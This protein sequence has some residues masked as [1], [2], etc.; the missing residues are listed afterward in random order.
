MA[1]FDL[2]ELCRNLAEK[3]I[4]YREDDKI[5][6]PNAEHVKR[7]ISQFDDIKR[8]SILQEMIHIM[9]KVYFSKSK[10]MDFLQ[11]KV[12]NSKLVGND[13]VAFWNDVTLLDIQQGSRSQSKMKSL[14]S[15]IL[16][17]KYGININKVNSN[18]GIYIYLDDVCFSG[19]RIKNDIIKWLS[20]VNIKGLTINKINIIT[21]ANHSNGTWWAE[22]GIN[23]EMRKLN[24]NFKIDFWTCHTYKNMLSQ[25]NEADVFSPTSL[26]DDPFVTKYVEYLKSKGFP[27][28]KLR[29]VLPNPQKP[30]I[31][32]NEEN[33]N[34]IEQEFLIKGAY[35]KD[36]CTSLSEK[37][38]P[39]GF[40]LLNTLGFGSSIVTFNNCSNTAPLVLWAD[41]PWYPLF[42]R[43]VNKYEYL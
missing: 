3:I 1:H 24:L 8:I 25:L 18:N 30:E 13:A 5:P 40:S 14:L 9:D 22:K 16:Q 10:V 15:S 20:K 26:P 23:E 12:C 35:I 41:D 42:P 38:R 21:M 39:L 29:H 37:I 4:D 7:W 33:R 34:L 17:Q 19:N 27:P 43:R 36:K 28:E 32:S 11:E 2:Q 31:F 6:A